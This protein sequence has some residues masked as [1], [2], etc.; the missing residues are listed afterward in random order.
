MARQDLDTG[1]SRLSKSQD[2]F[3]LVGRSAGNGN[4]YDINLKLLYQERETIGAPKDRHAVNPHSILSL[5]VIDESYRRLIPLRMV[6]QIEGDELATFS[7]TDDQHAELAASHAPG[8]G[9]TSPEAGDHGAG[10]R[11]DCS[12]EYDG[13]RY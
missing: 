9:K 1:G 11:E 7:R 5:V 8:I 4:A 10:E 6:Q 13:N 3:K 2:M 12:H